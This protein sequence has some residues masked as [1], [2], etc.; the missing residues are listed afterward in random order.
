V[1]Q[2][3]AA[4]PSILGSGDLINTLEPIV[5]HGFFSLSTCSMSALKALVDIYTYTGALPSSV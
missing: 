3:L 1:E 4:R 5:S 2:V